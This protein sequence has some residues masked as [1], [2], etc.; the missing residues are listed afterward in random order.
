MQSHLW[1][2]PNDGWLLMPSRRLRYAEYG[3]LNL[4]LNKS[5]MRLFL[6]GEATYSRYHIVSFGFN[7]SNVP[8][9]FWNTS[10]CLFT[11]RD[12][13]LCFLHTEEDID[14]AFRFL[15]NCTLKYISDAIAIALSFSSNLWRYK[16]YLAISNLP[17]TKHSWNVS[18]GLKTLFLR[19]FPILYVTVQQSS[20]SILIFGQVI[21]HSDDLFKLF[22]VMLGCNN[23][24]ISKKWQFCTLIPSVQNGVSS[25][26]K[27]KLYKVNFNFRT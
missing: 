17:S 16:K 1:Y 8:S 25:S 2:S 6:W 15:S 12:C 11:E 4:V 7:S 14:S 3:T 18:G 22:D 24:A 27:K 19:L 23:R 13:T 5:C 26:Y 9:S 20:L 10:L 21:Q